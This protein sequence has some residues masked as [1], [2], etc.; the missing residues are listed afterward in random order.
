LKSIGG[1]RPLNE[2]PIWSGI[3]VILL[4][5]PVLW[6]KLESLGSCREGE[7]VEVELWSS[8]VFRKERPSAELLEEFEE[9]TL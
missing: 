1:N 3:L 6:A 4:L 9:N 2:K 8:A 7:G 5:L